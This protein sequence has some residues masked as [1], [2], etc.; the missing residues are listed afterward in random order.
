MNRQQKI[1]L[2]AALVSFIATMIG[3]GAVADLYNDLSVGLVLLMLLFVAAPGVLIYRWVK[4][5]PDTIEKAF[6][7]KP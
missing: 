5:N 7:I 6:S 2:R 1:F 3:F 4:C